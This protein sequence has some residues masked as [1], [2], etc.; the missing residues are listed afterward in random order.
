ASQDDNSSK[1][2]LKEAFLTEL[3]RKQKQVAMKNAA[4]REEYMAHYKPWRLSVWELDRSRNK[5]PMTPG[6]ASP[7]PPTVPVTPTVVPDSRER[8]YKGNSELDFLNALKASEISAQEELERRKTQMVTARPDL[9]REAIIPDMLESGEAKARI[10]KDVNNAVKTDDA[11][12]VFGFLPPANDFTQKEHEMFTDAFMTYPKKWDKIAEALPGR[13]FQQCIV[14]YYLTK[15]EIKYKA[16]LNKRWSK[17]GKGKA[18]VKGPKSNLL[19]ADL[20]VVKPDFDGEEDVPA[21]TDTGRPRRAAA[22]TFGDSNDGQTGKETESIEKPAPRRGARVG[23]TRAPKRSKTTE[24]DQ[25]TQGPPPAPAP[26]APPPPPPPPPP[27]QSNPPLA[28]FPKMEFGG[29]GAM[30]G[31]L[32]L[33]REMSEREATIPAS[34]PR[35]GRG[36]AK[37]GVYVFESTETDPTMTPKPMEGGYGSLQPTSYWS[38]PEQ[39]DFPRL[40]AHFGRDFEGISHFMK[41]KTTVMVKNYYQRRLDSGQKDFEDLLLIAEDKKTRGEPTGPLPIPSVAPKRRYEA[42]PST[43]VPRPLAPHGDLMAEADELRFSSKGKPLAMSPQPMPLHGRPLSDNERGANRYPTL[44]QASNV[45]PGPPGA[46]N[47]SEDALTMR[48]HPNRMSGPRL[49]YFTEDRRESSMLPHSVPHGQEMQISSR[50]TPAGS[51]IPADLARMDA[52]SGQVYMTSQAQPSILGPTHSRHPSLTQAPGSPTQLHRS[53]LDISSV[54]RD[55][56]GQRQY[57]S[58]S[59]QPGG[60]QSPRPVLSPVKDVP[61]LSG[62]PAPDS[63]VPAKRSNI[64]SILNDEPEE[65]QP[66]KRFASEAPSAPVSAGASGQRSVFQNM[67]PTRVDENSMS[68]AKPSG[69]GQPTQYQTSARGYPEYPSYGPPPGS[70]GTSGT[71]SDWMARFDPRSQQ[72]GSQPQPPPPS[73]HGSNRQTASLA[74]QNPYSHY[75]SAQSQSASQMN[76]LTVP[77]PVPTPP[78]GSQRPAYPNVFSQQSSSQVHG[79]SNSRDMTSQPQAYRPGS[80]S[81]RASS[82]AFGSRQDPPTPAQP[83]ASLYGM[84]APRQS[85]GQSA[86]SPVTPSTPVSAQPLGQSY[87][88]HVQTFVNG[89]HRSTPVNLAGGPPAYGHSTPPP[90]GQTGRSMAALSGLGRSYTPPAGM[91]PSMGSNGMGY[92]QPSSASASMQNLHQR[93]PGPGSLGEPTSTPT[94]HRVYSQG[95]VQGGMP[96]LHPSSQPPR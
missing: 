15:E 28:A 57:Y 84:V 37:E 85:G 48:G 6:P 33:D 12:D 16:K 50:N 88:Q 8:R 59:S 53:E 3:C 93:P 92:A 70:A 30:E 38:V 14:H 27:P 81:S 82:V 32:P 80:P 52:L 64:M 22:P 96:P 75:A 2:Q 91:H 29:D 69:Y 31:P 94:H 76:N 18:R 43:I 20:G 90:Q 24:K 1:S 51:S 41:T 23:G 55:P 56:F 10:Y 13:D 62:T 47:I 40:L 35:V 7:P 78:P 74:S 72:G 68:G 87:Q 11:L 44:A 79:P 77:S 39:R 67:G 54:H 83:S 5:K 66:R 58:L 71:T 4:L 95:S 60:L 21:V 36:R 49:G 63:K 42:T 46:T 45:A 34:R 89:A 17:K 61:R 26:V 19:I 65:P 86:Y 73:Q 25:R 9:S